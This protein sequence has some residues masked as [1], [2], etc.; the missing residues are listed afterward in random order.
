MWYTDIHAFEILTHEILKKNSHKKNEPFTL[1]HKEHES[2]KANGKESLPSSWTSQPLEQGEI[3]VHHF[4]IAAH[5][6][7]DTSSHIST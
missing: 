5:I 2:R 6:Y 7:S 3:N 1:P 4:I